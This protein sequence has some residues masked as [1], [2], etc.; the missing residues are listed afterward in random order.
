MVSVVK[1][2]MEKVSQ[3]KSRSIP[4]LRS[5]LCL[6]GV[7]PLLHN[8]DISGLGIS[9]GSMST[10]FGRYNAMWSNYTSWGRDITR[11]DLV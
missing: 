5:L 4:S 3:P 11:P 9:H 8:L 1:G 10:G 2:Q 7:L 6:T